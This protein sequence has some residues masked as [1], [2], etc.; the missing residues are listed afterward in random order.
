VFVVRG[1]SKKIAVKAQTLNTHKN[2]FAKASIVK[3]KLGEIDVKKLNQLTAEH[4]LKNTIRK[5]VKET[6]SRP[7]W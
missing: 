6:W 2:T 3:D 7:Q 5:P 1:K 4:T